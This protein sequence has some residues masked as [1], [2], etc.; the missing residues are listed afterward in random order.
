MKPIFK[1]ILISMIPAMVG[2][3]I[4]IYGLTIDSEFTVLI[5]GLLIAISAFIN[6]I[7]S[8]KE[9][10]LAKKEL[11]ELLEDYVNNDEE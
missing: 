2:L 7:A 1:K 3:P 8:N 6:A 4:G 5:G 11:L 10:R 9:A